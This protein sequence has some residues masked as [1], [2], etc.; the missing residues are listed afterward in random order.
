M[1]KDREKWNKKYE[2]EE[3][4]WEKPSE[5]VEKFYT[6]AKNKGKV[7]DLACGL[8]RNSIFLAK[9]G[10]K[11]DAVDISDV[12]LQKLKEK[13]PQVNTINADLDTYNIPENTYDLIININYLN[14][15]LVPQIKEALKKDGLII[16]ETFT[17][18]E[19][20]DIMQPK[21]KDYLLR[22]NELLRLFSDLYIVFYQEKK[23]TKP[24]GEKAFVSS[25][26]AVKKCLL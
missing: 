15:R 12:A 1:E 3:Y 14:R 10:F 8:G 25:L 2:T 24:N 26:V 13:E 17:L 21:N 11:V 20:K 6:L 18:S 16:F 5:I 23:I 19:D 22:P 4:P 7:L 9:K